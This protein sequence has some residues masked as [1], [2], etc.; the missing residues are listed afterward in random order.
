LLENLRERGV[1]FI[2]AGRDDRRVAQVA[3]EFDSPSRVFTLGDDTA[4]D[5]ALSGVDVVLN[6]AGPFLSTT[7][8]LLRSCLRNRVHYLDVSGEVGPLEHVASLHLQARSAGVMML[9]AVGFDVVPSDCLALHLAKRLPSARELVL[10]ISGSNLLSRG[11]ARAFADHAGIPV[12]VRKRG[13]LEPILFRTQV[14]WVDFGSETRPVIAVSWGDLVT[15]FRSTGIPDI[16][17]YFEATAARW[18]VIGL[19][20]YFGW[21][22]GSTWT[23]S[24]LKS[25]LSSVPEGPTPQKRTSENAIIVGEARDGR[26]RVRARLVTPEAYTFTG[27]AG[28]AVAER[29]LGGAIEPGFQT[30]AALLGADF[31]LSMPGVLREDL[32]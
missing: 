3:S 11:S 14:R 28:A 12:Y 23:R 18:T 5:R 31:V 20:Q 30:P 6:A 32:C 26:Q 25:Y 13:R 16:E 19:N 10:S 24:W 9:P 8:P 4:I 22:M 17:I 27:M 21:M 29:V 7:A 15:A 1:A 2:A